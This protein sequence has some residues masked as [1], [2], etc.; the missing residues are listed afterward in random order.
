MISSEQKMMSTSPR[1]V[2]HE[3]NDYT[4][5]AKIQSYHAFLT[6]PCIMLELRFFQGLE[7]LKEVG[8]DQIQ[9]CVHVLNKI[10]LCPRVILHFVKLFAAR[11]CQH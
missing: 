10:M 5:S 8:H 4:F 11:Q 1:I 7:A 2:V 3:H 6:W 9:C